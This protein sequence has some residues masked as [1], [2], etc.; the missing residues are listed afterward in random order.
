VV[1]ITTTSGMGFAEDDAASAANAVA[2]PVPSAASDSSGR[3]DPYRTL[4][5]LLVEMVIPSLSAPDHGCAP[6]TPTR[7]NHPSNPG[8]NTCK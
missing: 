6:R 4:R 2:P 8:K 1:P 3:A 7:E 5:S